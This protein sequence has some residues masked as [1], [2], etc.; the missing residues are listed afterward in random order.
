MRLSPAFSI[1]ETSY[2]QCIDGIDGLIEWYRGSG[3]RPYLA[4]LDDSERTEF[5]EELKAR[6]AEFYPLRAHGTLLMRIPRLSS[7]LSEAIK[8]GGILNVSTGA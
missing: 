1:W 8:V 5:I 6:L 2:G 4:V 7:F 3:L